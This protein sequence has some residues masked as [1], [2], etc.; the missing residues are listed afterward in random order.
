MNVAAVGDSAHVNNFTI[1]AL[2]IEIAKLKLMAANQDVIIKSVTK[3]LNF[4]L[5]Y[6]EIDSG[7]HVFPKKSCNQIFSTTT[8]VRTPV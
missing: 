8:Y 3:K 2:T 4:V 1:K 5:S 6:L 7:S